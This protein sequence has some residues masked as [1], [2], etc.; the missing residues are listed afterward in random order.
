MGKDKIQYLSH[1]EMPKGA[2]DNAKNTAAKVNKP[3]TKAV[4]KVYNKPRFFRPKCKSVARR[5]KLLRNINSVITKEGRNNVN[6]IM[7]QPVLRKERRQNGRGK[8]F[9][10]SCPSRC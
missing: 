7:L 9:D 3:V 8:Y 1:K 10:L 4:H 2:R 6:R 5:P